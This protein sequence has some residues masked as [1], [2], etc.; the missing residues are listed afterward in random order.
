MTDHLPMIPFLLYWLLFNCNWFFFSLAVSSC[1]TEISGNSRVSLNI[2]IFLNS[3]EKSRPM[4]W[5]PTDVTIN[6]QNNRS[7]MFS[8]VWYKIN[9]CISCSINVR[10]SST[11][12]FR[13]FK[14][15][16]KL[17]WTLP[18]KNIF[19]LICVFHLGCVSSIVTLISSDLG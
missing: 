5:A 1:T 7:Q 3:Q 8:E 4:F 13:S 14:S 19:H 11:G 17:E 15:S 9:I 16:L 6:A 2:Y 18:K 12:N 10:N